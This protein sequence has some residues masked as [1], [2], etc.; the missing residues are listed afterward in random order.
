MQPRRSWILATCRPLEI[1]RWDRGDDRRTELLECYGGVTVWQ[2]AKWV[3]ALDDT[4]MW[5][6][7]MVIRRLLGMTSTATA[8][9]VLST[10]DALGRR[11]RPA[12]LSH[13]S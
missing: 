11:A 4:D 2:A 9:T 3:G 6:K 1:M 13:H 5:D 10:V 8:D 7:D 12:G